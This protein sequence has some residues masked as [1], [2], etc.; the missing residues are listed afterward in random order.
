MAGLY[1]NNSSE[2]KQDPEGP[3]LRAKD[4]VADDSIDMKLRRSGSDLEHLA[5]DGVGRDE[6]SECR[7]GH[8]PAPLATGHRNSRSATTL[9]SGLDSA[10]M[11]IKG[12]FSCRKALK[13]SAVNQTTA[14]SED[15]QDE[16]Q[17]QQSGK[18][19]ILPEASIESKK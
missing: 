10:D 4:A 7:T 14:D 18:S 11:T 1:I 15:S 6:N 17:T 2:I 5:A 16:Q 13:I 9:S 12:H 19:L 8:A 3:H